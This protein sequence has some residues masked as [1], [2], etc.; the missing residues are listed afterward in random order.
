MLECVANVSEGRDASVIAALAAAAGPLLLDVHSDPHHHRSVFTLAGGGVEEAV[1]RLAR[2]AVAGVDLRSHRGAHPR[3]G[4]LDVVPFVALAGSSA[5]EATGARDR[6]A[7]WAAEELGLPCF[8]YGPERSLPTVRRQAFV[9]LAPDTG[10]AS[11]HPTGGAVAVGTRGPL[12]A[13][14]LWLAPGVGLGRAMA[15]AA[16]VRGPGIRAIGVATG[17]STQV[18][19]N[20][21]E[22]LAVGPDAAFDAVA[23]RVEVAQAEL[24]GLVPAS[25][26]AAIPDGRW[27]E[28]DLDPSRTIEARL[29]QAGLDGGSSGRAGRGGH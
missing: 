17:G 4:A 23:A 26:L 25:V 1:R 10:P 5:A 27:A 13:Y 6:F 12:V 7:R 11:P 18:S 20:L 15:V 2:V 22:P 16:A 19:C 28:L 29:E 3:L 21:I 8:T 24:V 14:N 9:T